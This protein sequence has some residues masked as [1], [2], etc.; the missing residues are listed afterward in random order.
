MDMSWIS[1]N[2]SQQMC[3]KECFI[4]HRATGGEPKEFIKTEEFN[5]GEIEK[6]R[7]VQLDQALIHTNWCMACSQ[8]ESQSRIL[9]DRPTDQPRGR[10]MTLLNRVSDHY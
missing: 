7:S 8:P 4:T 3:M 2:M 1:I 10:S 6:R 5:T 9:L